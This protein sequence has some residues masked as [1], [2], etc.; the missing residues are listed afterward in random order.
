MFPFPYWVSWLFDKIDLWMSCAK[1]ILCKK[2]FE[3]SQHFEM[4]EDLCGNRNVI[5]DLDLKV[6]PDKKISWVWKA[7]TYLARC[8]TVLLSLKSNDKGDNGDCKLYPQ[9]T[10][11]NFDSWRNVF[12]MIDHDFYAKSLN[13][14]KTLWVSD[15]LVS[16]SFLLSCRGMINEII[17]K[18]CTSD[19]WELR[20]CDWLRSYVAPM[21]EKMRQ[22]SLQEAW[23]SDHQ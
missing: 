5:E 6:K 13:K 16:V 12:C 19:T 10:C 8:K 2:S 22:R 20:S 4:S 18:T 21:V 1:K 23:T 17:S 9:N 15:N 14:L 7:F 3:K 11:N